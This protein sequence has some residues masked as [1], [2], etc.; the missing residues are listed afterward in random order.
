MKKTFLWSVAGTA[1]V[2]N[3][4]GIGVGARLT[5][6][7][8]SGSIAIAAA[9]PPPVAPRP[10]GEA[11]QKNA[12]NF[13]A[14]VKTVAPSVLTIKTSLENKVVKAPM[15][16]GR[17]GAVPQGRSFEDLFEQ[18]GFSFGGPPRQRGTPSGGSGSGFVIDKTGIVVTN[19]HVVKDADTITVSLNED[20]SEEIPAKVIGTDP[21]TDIAVLK[22]D[23]GRELP[24]VEWADSNH[25]E[26]GDYAIA[27]GSPFMLTHSVTAGIVSAKGRNASRL[28]GADFGYELIQ[29]DTAINPGNSGGPLCTSDGKV[30]GV[31]TAIYTQSGGNMGIGF[32]IPSNVAKQVVASLLKDGKVVRGWLGVAIQ[33]A[34]KELKKELGIKGGVVVHEVQE[35]SH[36]EKAGLRAGNAIVQIGEHAVNKV[37]ELQRWVSERQPGEKIALK[38]VGYVDGKSRTVEVK[39]G[40]LPDKTVER[41]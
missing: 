4:I 11:L 27:I 35:D 1:L 41:S 31:N 9:A 30:M 10:D 17:S 6:P 29:T 19:Y 2:S 14:V 28:I 8:P 13:R 16:R 21:R 38:V 18:F 25:V 36:A 40:R 3:L 26:V 39:I 32:A 37:E 5:H 12:E 33:P 20:E 34:G 23:A 24:A 7:V 22:I 15:R